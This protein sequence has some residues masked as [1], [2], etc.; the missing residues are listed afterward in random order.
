MTA[1]EDGADRFP[2]PELLDRATQLEKVLFTQDVDFLVEA[3]R[4]QEMGIYFTGIV[5]ARQRKVTYAR[6]LSDLEMISKV[7]EL[8]QLASRVEYLPL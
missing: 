4:R 2:D 5:F 3:A 1:Q 7:G 8:S 6:C